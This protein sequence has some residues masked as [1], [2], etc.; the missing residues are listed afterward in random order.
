[1]IQHQH[2]DHEREGRHH[3]R[4]YGE[5][6]PGPKSRAGAVETPRWRC[7]DTLVRLR[8]PLATVCE[9][10]FCGLRDVRVRG[11]V[12]RHPLGATRVA[13]QI[14]RY[15]GEV[16]RPFGRNVSGEAIGHPDAHPH[17]VHTLRPCSNSASLNSQELLLSLT[18][19]AILAHPK[20]VQPPAQVDPHVCCDLRHM[21][22]RILWY[23]LHGF[24][25][26]RLVMRRSRTGWSMTRICPGQYRRR[27]GRLNCPAR[28]HSCL[29]ACAPQSPDPRPNRSLDRSGCREIRS[30]R[31]ILGLMVLLAFLPL[32]TSAK[33][34][35]ESLSPNHPAP[36]SELR[37]YGRLARQLSAVR[38]RSFKRAQVR[39]LRDGTT[40]YRGRLHDPNSLSLQYVSNASRARHHRSPQTR[41]SADML[42]VVTWNC[43]GLHQVRYAELITWLEAQDPHDPVHIMCVQE[44]HWPYHAEYSSGP[45]Q[46]V[47]SSCGTSS[48]GVMFIIHNTVANRGDIRYAETMPGRLL[49]LRIE[50]NPPIDLLGVYQ[51]SWN[52]HHKGLQGTNDEK[53]E[54]LLRNR[55]SVWE[56]LRG[57]T[58]SVPARNKLIILGDLNCTLNPASPSVGPGVAGH[59][60]KVHKD[61]HV[62]QHLLV[63]QGL[64]ATNTWGPSA[65]AGTFLQPSH[66]SIQLDFLLTRLPSHS[67]ELNATAQHHAPIVHP[68]GFRHVPVLGRFDFPVIPKKRTPPTLGAAAVLAAVRRDPSL[69][70][71]FRAAVVAELPRHTCLDQCLSRAWSLAVPKP[72]QSTA[73]APATLPPP[74]LKD[75]WGLK[76]NLRHALSAVDRYQAPL[77]WHIATASSTTVLRSFPGSRR[78]LQPF[79]RAWRA[80]VE[81]NRTQKL[82]RQRARQSK[83]TYVESLIQ[84]ALAAD[85][86]LSAVHRLTQRLRPK[87]SKRS[88]HFR[89]P[90]G[91]LQTP[92]EE[93]ATLGSYFKDLYQSSNAQPSQWS[94][95]QA[96]EVTDT[97]VRSALSALVVRKALPAGHAPAL[98]WHLASDLVHH[99]VKDSLNQ[100]LGSGKLEFD[101]EWNKSYLTLMPKVGKPPNCPANLRPINLLPAFPKMLARIAADR[102]KP[103]VMHALHG[104]PQYAYL[105]G[106]QTSDS[107]DRVLSHCQRITTKLAGLP[108]G[109]LGKSKLHARHQLTGGVQL[110]LD[111]KRAFDR[112]PRSK[113]LHALQRVQA[114]PDLISLV[115]YIHD[116]AE[117]VMNRHGQ[118]SSVRLGRGVRQGCGLSPILW[119]AFTVLVHDALGAYISAEALTG[120]ADDYH[121]WWEVATTLDFHNA[122]KQIC[123]I[124]VDLEALGM[125]VSIDKTVILM[126]IKG[127]AATRILKQYTHRT[128]EGRFLSAQW[129]GRAFQL[130]IKRKH[131]YLGVQIG[132]GHFIRDTAAYRI[133]Q[134]WVSFNRL[135]M[136][137]KHKALPL[138][139][140]LALWQSCV[141]SIMKYGLTAV[142]VDARSAGLLEAAV[143]KQLRY[144]ARSP[145][146]V[147]HETN[148]ELLARLRVP[149]PLSQLAHMC[150][151]RIAH[152]RHH[153]PHLL[154][155]RVLQWQEVV[156]ASFTRQPG[157]NHPAHLTEVTQVLRIRCQCSECGQ[158]FPSTHALSVHMGKAHAAA[159]ARKERNPTVKNQRKDEYRQHALR[160]RPQCRHC[161]KCFYG[162]PQF[163]GHFSQRACPILH[164]VTP[165]P[166][167]TPT[168]KPQPAD[169]GLST[170]IPC[171]A[172]IPC[173]WGARTGG[174]ANGSIYCPAAD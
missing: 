138:P 51:H 158:S 94:L 52:L 112:L 6:R 92:S 124:I 39:A 56:A 122:C 128:R 114:T 101:P 148:H 174:S 32:A 29:P 130:P 141:W 45:R 96:F 147:T 168:P 121:C 131:V 17:H 26:I 134:S 153:I 84:A 161:L 108:S 139:R 93:L 151:E 118:S 98:L 164:Y 13:L 5:G 140:R 62:F 116:S 14:R 135:R 109:A 48:G 85:R 53:L 16:H 100:A 80:S 73:T 2:R 113:L 61:A 95:L 88:I 172:A 8:I 67:R 41:P 83:N 64:V 1:M 144:V 167:V 60:R 163:M 160:G 146:H 79:L 157:P 90:T 23:L 125:E 34:P 133:Q 105:G 132:Y 104:L 20:S 74:T 30:M 107:L 97:E 143:A 46:F 47:H 68:T 31:F 173:S 42:R 75:F 4:Q 10:K 35:S 33:Q 65:K 18:A 71:R 21:H 137:L 59:G 169:P 11:S 69:A 70:D 24:F 22:M 156:L 103:L 115:M 102:L 170:D 142:G 55:A 127:S 119:L 159:G 86:G 38:K 89:R 106:R 49:H 25:V 152:S 149:P 129:Q 77:I 126:A 166:H 87:S 27:P 9:L 78:G 57:W 3:G 12:G 154:A 37:A 165:A 15:P 72:S 145:S 54:Q 155:D 7:E 162:W 136:F 66:S 40:S 19:Q 36:N 76:N 171:T 120:F 81:F 50:S 91:Q 99:R 117:V 123:R 44:T 58:S 43:G 28:L 110:S 63:S 150:Q 111:L 82:L